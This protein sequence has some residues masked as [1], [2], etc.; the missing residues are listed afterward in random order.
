MIDYKILRQKL[1]LL[2]ISTVVLIAG[3]KNADYDSICSCIALSHILTKLG[4]NAYALIESKDASKAEWL[5]TS[6]VINEYSIDKPFNFILLDSPRKERLGKFEPLFDKAQ[7]T[8][9]IDHHEIL[10]CEATYT[11]VD[12]HISST[13]EIIATLAKGYP[14]ILDKNIATLLYAGIVSDTNSFY[15]RVTPSTM[16]IAS[17]LMQY[18]V[19]NT[20]VVKN[21]SRNLSLRDAT[22]ISHMLRHL[23][24]DTLHFIVLDRKDN[25]IS[26]ITYD[27][28]FKRCASFIY[29]LRDIDIFGLFLIELDGSVSG[30]LRSNTH[31]N[32]DGIAKEFGGGGHKKAAGFETSEDIEIILE[33]VKKLIKLQG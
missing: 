27:T 33:K 32:V 1:E 8:I 7:M 4:Y 9:C 24:Y 14:N 30:L 18:N 28:L 5:N 17:M 6:L 13:A 11:F 20:F 29:D 12:E 21:T 31:V 19:D 10:K 3:H 26:N 2:P 23:E 22:I 25:L 16:T 15:R